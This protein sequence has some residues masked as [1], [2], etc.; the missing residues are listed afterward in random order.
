MGGLRF[1]L[2]QEAIKKKQPEVLKLYQEKFLYLMVDEYQDTNLCQYLWLGLLA[3]NHKN[4]CCVGDDDQSIYG[5]QSTGLHKAL[6]KS[7]LLI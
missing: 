5:C 1:I 3:K 4:I 7:S 6:K 2:Q